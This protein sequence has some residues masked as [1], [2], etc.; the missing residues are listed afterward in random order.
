MLTLF[1]NFFAVLD[2][3]GDAKLRN[4]EDVWLGFKLESKTVDDDGYEEFLHAML[5]ETYSKWQEIKFNHL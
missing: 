5:F 2:D 3:V 1:F 4:N